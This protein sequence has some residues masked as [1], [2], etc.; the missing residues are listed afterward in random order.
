MD[1]NVAN[2]HAYPWQI[3]M[4]LN[5]T[6]YAKQHT[7]LAEQYSIVL[8]DDLKEY[9]EK[10]A[11]AASELRHNCG[12]SI[13]SPNY[14]LTAA[15]CVQQKMSDEFKAMFDTLP[16]ES[17]LFIYNH[18]AE[19]IFIVVG[20]HNRQS[21]NNN[22]IT[23]TAEIERNSN[24]R[25]VFNVKIHEQYKS[26]VINIEYDFVIVKLASP[27][28]YSASVAPVCLPDPAFSSTKYV[29]RTGTV[30]GWGATNPDGMDTSTVLKDL[31]VTVLSNEECLEKLHEVVDDLGSVRGFNQTIINQLKSEL[32]LKRYGRSRWTNISRFTINN[33][34]YFQC[35]CVCIWQCNCRYRHGV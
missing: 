16:P 29:G 23:I 20:A 27:L 4:S 35:T 19:E 30:S 8:P 31:E 24:I 26:S 7:N 21:Y 9:I 22:K 10:L 25:R 6:E 1:G 18:P 5:I 32:Q 14:V 3:S 12:G 33:T 28:T 15:H 13:I 34:I 17:D 11:E 2:P